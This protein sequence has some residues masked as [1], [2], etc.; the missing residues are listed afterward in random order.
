MTD[1]TVSVPVLTPTS[2]DGSSMASGSQI[3][4]EPIFPEFPHLI[5]RK[6]E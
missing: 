6:A 4:R 3:S 5:N 1:A 2:K